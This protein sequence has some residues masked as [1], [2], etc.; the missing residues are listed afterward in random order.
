MLLLWATSF[1]GHTQITHTETEKIATFCK[2]WGFLKYYHPQVSKG[3]YNWDSQL[4]E[5][6]PLIKSCNSKEA[7]SRLYI[8]WV[9]SLGKIKPRKHFTDSTSRSFT[10]NLNV[11]WINDT[12]MFNNE[13]IA[14]L[15]YIKDNRAR[16]NHYVHKNFFSPFFEEKKY[17]DSVYPSEGLR[18]VGLFRYWNIINYFAP[19]KYLTDYDW[20]DVLIEM[21]PE[22]QSPKDTIA[23]HHAIYKLVSRLDD[24]HAVFASKYTKQ[25][26]GSKYFPYQV[27]VVEN[28]LIITGYFNDSIC[29]KNKLVY[30]DVITLINGTPIE[31]LLSDK[32]SQMAGSNQ[33]FKLRNMANQLLT[34]DSDSVNLTVDR[35]NQLFNTKIQRYDAGKYHYKWNEPKWPSIEEI[36]SETGYVNM[37]ALRKMQVKKVMKGLMDKKAIIFDLRCYPNGTGRKI[38]RYLCK[39]KSPFSVLITPDLTFPGMFYWT[40]KQYCGKERNRNYYK[41]KVI[42]LMNENTMSQAEYTCMAFKTLPDVTFIGSQTAGADGDVLP[43]TFPGGYSTYFSGLGVYYP[44]GTTTQRIGIIPDIEVKPTIEGIRSGKDEVFEKA[45]ELINRDEQND[46]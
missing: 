15:N 41:G 38:S 39:E 32:L 6:L 2:V 26:N 31:N 28:K 9:N 33:S 27:K 36:D 20:N 14:Q 11:G 29:K 43:V 4:I 22:F 40:K 19:Y 23:Y 34:G 1:Y 17:N 25:Y 13:L 44:D 30:G 35:Q 3:K 42:V 24:S 8:D 21:I 10:K 7:S 16:R 45:M 37:G 12:A 5:K 46:L 18:M